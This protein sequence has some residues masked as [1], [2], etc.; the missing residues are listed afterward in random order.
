MVME[1]KKI[2]H[3]FRSCPKPRMTALASTIIPRLINYLIYQPV[4][5]LWDLVHAT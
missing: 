3:S 1:R 4:L 5:V 2:G